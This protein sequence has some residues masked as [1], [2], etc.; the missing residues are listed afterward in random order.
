MSEIVPSVL[1]DDAPPCFPANG[2]FEIANLPFA[3]IV[4]EA[5]GMGQGDG[6]SDGGEVADH[7][8][9]WATGDVDAQG[10]DGGDVTPLHVGG[11]GSDGG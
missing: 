3:A 10:D 2:L 11:V 5:N 7:A 1:Y 6:A 9:R 4:V 8:S